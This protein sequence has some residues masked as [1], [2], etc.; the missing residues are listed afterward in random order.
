MIA[1]ESVEKEAKHTW[2]N[3]LE[4]EEVGIILPNLY[5]TPPTPVT[6]GNLS[7]GEMRF[8]FEEEDRVFGS[9]KF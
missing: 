6:G 2:I 9:L 1:K 4:Q 5:V 3:E 7:L 8:T